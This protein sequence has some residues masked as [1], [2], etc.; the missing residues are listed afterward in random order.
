[1]NTSP[2]HHLWNCLGFLLISLAALTPLRA[3]IT[4]S[5]TQQFN[6][7]S[8]SG[9]KAVTG[10][11]T[12]NAAGASKLVVVVGSEHGFNNGAGD[13][14]T[15]KYNGI[16]LIPAVESKVDRGTAEIWYLDN[17]GSIGSGT[18]ESRPPIPMAA[19]AR[20]TPCSSLGEACPGSATPGPPR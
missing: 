10:L 6:V 14:T 7:Q 5:S 18:I 17:P 12:F 13:V 20:P 19:L 16:D 1:M 11:G 4:I 8:E 9:L 2:R 3:Q 15:V